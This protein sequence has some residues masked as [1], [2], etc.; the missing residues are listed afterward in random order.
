M[1]INKLYLHA[2]LASISLI[3]SV[4]FSE[5]KEEN[6]SGM[7]YLFV[8]ALCLYIAIYGL[9]AASIKASKLET[10]KENTTRTIS[11]SKGELQAPFPLADLIIK[12][13]ADSKT[14]VEVNTQEYDMHILAENFILVAIAAGLCLIYHVFKTNLLVL[15]WF[16]GFSI[17]SALTSPLFETH[18]LRRPLP[19]PYR[20]PSIKDDFYEIKK[21]FQAIKKEMKKELDSLGDEMNGPKK[22]KK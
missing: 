19:R 11:M 20:V 15:L 22:G 14:L 4:A 6:V 12:P 1:H 5:E 9:I 18:I 8:G 7:R 17:A 2:G 3:L 13:T 16:A 10:T 21:G